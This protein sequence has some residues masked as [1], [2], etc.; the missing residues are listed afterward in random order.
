M[1]SAWLS[2][3]PY[4]QQRLRPE[5]SDS[6][7]RESIFSTGRVRNN[8]RAY[9]GCSKQP[10]VEHHI[11]PLQVWNTDIHEVGVWGYFPGAVQRAG[12]GRFASCHETKRSPHGVLDVRWI[13]P[14]S[15]SDCCKLQGILSNRMVYYGVHGSRGW[16]KTN[17][18][19]EIKIEYDQRKLEYKMVYKLVEE[20]W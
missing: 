9:R 1:F 11:A 19:K 18:E 20:K 17:D 12:D 7:P 4:S 15:K 3:S 5:Q 10:V 14:W 13:D 8:E 6:L 2:V 16:Y